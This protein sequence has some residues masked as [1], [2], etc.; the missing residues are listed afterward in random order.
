VGVRLRVGQQSRTHAPSTS[1]RELWV[2][3][4]RRPGGESHCLSANGRALQQQCVIHLVSWQLWTDTAGSSEAVSLHTLQ[5]IPSTSRMWPSCATM[6]PG[7]VPAKM[8]C[9]CPPSL[10]HFAQLITIWCGH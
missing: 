8:L 1:Q 9:L 3:G 5:P 6:K 2:I 4:G 10:P 7:K